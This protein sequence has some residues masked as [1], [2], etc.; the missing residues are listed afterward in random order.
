MGGSW[1]GIAGI[2][3]R[4]MGICE[5]EHR[6]KKGSQRWVADWIS[7]LTLHRADY[8][9]ILYNAALKAGAKIE[10]GKK[11]TSIDQ[12]APSLT[13]EDG[14]VIRTDLIIAADGS[15][16]LFFKQ[17]GINTEK[18]ASGR[19]SGP[20]SSLDSMHNPHLTAPTALSCLA[21]SCSALHF[22]PPLLRLQPQ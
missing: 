4:V 22:Y 20:R 14:S 6:R 1:D 8:Q 2:Q 10:F 13:M 3:W 18:Q 17:Q 16:S 12:S 5:F 15:S 19:R 21:L 9:R 7:N 11:V